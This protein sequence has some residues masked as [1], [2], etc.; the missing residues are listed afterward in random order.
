MHSPIATGKMTVI[1]TVLLIGSL[2]IVNLIA[3]K[4]LGQREH[5]LLDGTQ[6]QYS[7]IGDDFPLDL[8]I[9]TLG[10]ID[11]SI[12]ESVRFRLSQ[13]KAVSDAWV[14]NL[15]KGIGFVR[16]G[17]GK[18]MFAVSMYHEMHCLFEIHQEISFHRGPNPHVQHCLNYIRQN[19]LCTADLTLEPLEHISNGFGVN[20]SA[21]GF[22]R[23]C[24]DWSA[25]R[26]Y[27]EGNYLEWH[28]SK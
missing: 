18:R 4:H 13:D 8:P 3:L 20:V 27:I 12:E 15:P 26:I 6:T 28:S 10:S 11:A 14:Y 17:E 7:Y 5:V 19:I 2:L 22:S 21:G 23:E 25:A 24:R 1:K 9:P 16:L